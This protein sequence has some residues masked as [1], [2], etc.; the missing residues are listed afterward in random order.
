MN[1]DFAFAFIPLVDAWM[2]APG[3][4]PN[5]AGVTNALNGILPKATG[6]L[7]KLPVPSDGVEPCKHK[8]KRGADPVFDGSMALDERGLGGPFGGLFKTAFSLVTCVIDTTNKVK[9]TVVG[10]AENRVNLVEDLMSDLRPMVDA[11]KS[12]VPTPGDDP[13]T[14]KADKPSSTQSDTSSSSSSSS[15]CTV[16]TVSSCSIMCTASAT[17]TVRGMAR[18]ANGDGCTTVCNA[19]ITKCGVTGTTSASASTSTLTEV[20]KCAKNCSACRVPGPPPTPVPG[21]VYLTDSKGVTLGPSPTIPPLPTN[22]SVAARDAMP[23]ESGRSRSRLEKRVL[24]NPNGG[25]AGAWLV[26]M[27]RTPGA[28]RIDPN[29]LPS[30]EDSSTVAETR[31]LGQHAVNVQ[32][33][34]MQ[35]CTAVM[36]V[37]RKRIWL[38]HIWQKPTM[39]A[40]FRSAE[41]QRDAVDALIYGNNRGVPQGIGL[42][43]DN[44]F[45]NTAENNV[46]AYISK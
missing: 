20:I 22:A 41:F 18:R 25:D 42:Y 17:T 44:D 8:R 24:S 3:N 30:E 27:L 15:S 11:L 46:N 13:T 39:D 9:D 40:G 19:P 35:G 43:Y 12:V 7:G 1:R 23:L 29:L 37:S 14:S 32:V 38:A 28:V 34:G 6:F 26:A 16:T 31:E 10:Q 4:A 33:V 5:V 36:I 21:V 2:N 45:A